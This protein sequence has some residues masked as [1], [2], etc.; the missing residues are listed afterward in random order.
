MG[1]KTDVPLRNARPD[2]GGRG[3]VTPA[4]FAFAASS[5]WLPR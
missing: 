3:L 5:V 4:A 2:V 1:A